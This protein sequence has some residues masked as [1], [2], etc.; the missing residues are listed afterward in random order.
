[1]NYAPSI[2]WKAT[3]P[4]STASIL[5]PMATVIKRI[6]PSENEFLASLEAKAKQPNPFFRAMANRPD[7]LK[8]FV[9][10]YGALRGTGAAE[11]RSKVLAYRAASF[12][13]PYPFFLAA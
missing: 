12:L 1:M 2:S 13:N 8:S 9:P 11:R 7:A 10:F 6:D 4:F 3:V 5:V